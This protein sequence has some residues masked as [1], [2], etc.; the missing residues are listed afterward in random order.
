MVD[1]CAKRWKL[2]SKTGETYIVPSERGPR[3]CTQL[4]P[5]RFP[6]CVPKA[7]WIVISHDLAR[8]GMM[9]PEEFLSGQ[10]IALTDFLSSKE[11]WLRVRDAYSYSELC[12][13]G[14]NAFHS[15]SCGCFS[16]ATLLL[17]RFKTLMPRCRE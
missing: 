5:N 4:I 3:F 9:S 14:G 11:D 8:V 16:V 12:R 7:K 2:C 1:F 17:P 10:Q 15:S 6:T 13:F